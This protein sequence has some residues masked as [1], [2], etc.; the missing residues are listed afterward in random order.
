MGLP[1]L[2]ALLLGTRASTPGP[3][4]VTYVRRRLVGPGVNY[5]ATS[6]ANASGTHMPLGLRP[7]DTPI[8]QVFLFLRQLLNRLFFSSRNTQRRSPTRWCQLAIM[9]IPET[10][11]LFRG[12]SSA[13]LG[14]TIVVILHGVPVH[15]STHLFP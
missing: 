13:S 8:G 6:I 9:G 10:A 15:S 7:F 2:S 14:E 4:A 11:A 1:K 12:A 3:S 5:P